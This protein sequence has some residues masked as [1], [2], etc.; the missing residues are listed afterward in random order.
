MCPAPCVAPDHQ[1][2]HEAANGW[3]LQ[4]GRQHQHAHMPHQ[5]TVARITN[6]GPNLPFL[7]TPIHDSA[8]Q[9]PTAQKVELL[10]FWQLRGGE[11]EVHAMSRNAKGVWS[12]TRPASWTNTCVMTSYDARGGRGN[13]AARAC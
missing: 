7:N 2:A 4:A 11:P 3:F 1:P 8:L 5:Q 10:H 13:G 12:V 6:T 9:A